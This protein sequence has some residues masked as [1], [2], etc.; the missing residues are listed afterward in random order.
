MKEAFMRVS[1]NE[2]VYY[3]RDI[4]AMSRPELIREAKFTN[5]ICGNRI[6]KPDIMLYLLERKFNSDTPDPSA[7]IALEQSRLVPYNRRY[8]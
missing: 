1:L 2:V 5:K 8:S 7:T 6:S 4:M 3:L